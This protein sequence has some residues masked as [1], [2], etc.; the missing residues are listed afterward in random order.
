MRYRALAIVAWATLATSVLGGDAGNRLASLDGPVDPYYVGLHAPKLITPQ[1]VGEPGVEAV[2]VLAVDDLGKPDVYEQFL[3]PIL[4]RLKTAHAGAGMSIMTSAADPASPQIAQ[5]LSE[6]VSIEAHTAGH[7][8]PLLQKN[9]LAAAKATYDL[10]IDNL[11][12]IPS[13]RTVAFRMPCCDSMNSVSPRFFTEIF[14]RT[15]PAGRFLSLD[16]SVFQVFTADD[17]D[18]PREVVVDSSGKDRFTKYIPFD[19]GMINTIENYPYPYVLGGLCWEF[20]C[21]MPSDWDAQQLNGKCSPTTLQDLQAAVD[22]TVK[23]QGVFSLCFHPHGWIENTQVVAMIDYALSHYAG[24]VRFLSFRDVADRLTTNALRGHALRNVA[25]ADNGVRVLD[26]DHDGYLDVA[27]GNDQAQFSR[28]W[29]PST[30]QWLDTAFPVRIVS[31]IS[32]GSTAE[33][34]VRFGVFQSGGGAGLIY[35]SEP[36]ALQPGE[37]SQGAWQFV[38]GAW[39][40]SSL[41]PPVATQAQGR[42]RG[43]RLVDVDNDGV[44]ELFVA[45]SEQQTV[46]RAG[47]RVGSSSL[48]HCRPDW[49]LSMRRVAMRACGWWTR[50]VTADWISFSPMR[51]AAQ[52]T[53]SRPGTE[54]WAQCWLN[55]PRN[56]SDSL[57]M[58]VRADGTNNG[59]WFRRRVDVGPKRGRGRCG[60]TPSRR[61]TTGQTGRPAAG[62]ARSP[63]KP[64]R[65]L[66]RGSEPKSFARSAGL[67]HNGVHA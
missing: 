18:L 47:P 41:L 10:C 22:A 62:R 9:S 25:G 67:N 16:S 46:Y 52:C 21:L 53:S 11:A 63:R 55:E 40:P 37:L 26:L 1:W 28:V 4:N 36:S 35:R 23:K 14:N 17:P 51:N 5:W 31:G 7:P 42:D 27:V 58:I 29:Q 54:G 3:R 48:G 60:R 13:S 45:N 57:P 38:D 2:I 39:Q 34:G 6:G 44:C 66:P 30:G 43:V 64:A 19:R 33:T 50:I 49:H 61:P 15:T 56:S 24:K 8:C 32:G 65:R 59:A 12:T 20:P